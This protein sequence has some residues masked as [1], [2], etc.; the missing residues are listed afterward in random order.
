M[1]KQCR[2]AVA[3]GNG[4]Y[5]GQA[6]AVAVMVGGEIAVIT[7]L[8]LAAKAVCGYKVQ[9]GI[10]VAFNRKLN[11]TLINRQ[12]LTGCNRI[13]QDIADDIAQVNAFD[14]YVF[15]QVDF[16][17]QVDARFLGKLMIVVQNG[18][19]R[20]VFAECDGIVFGHRLKILVDIGSCRFKVLAVRKLFQGADGV[21][22][23]VAHPGVFVN[24]LLLLEIL[25]FL[26]FIKL[27]AFLCLVGV[28]QT[29][30]DKIKDYTQ[31]QMQNK[32]RCVNE[33]IGAK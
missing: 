3:L 20:V 28:V 19:D 4:L 14:G 29:G 17:I 15:G 6:D 10:V 16:P 23:I 5:R 22:E 25:T 2:A 21:F 11:P 24:I 30:N 31:Q 13:I 33:G 32:E 26:H 9:V 8:Y 12:F 27:V 7:E 18:I 1:L